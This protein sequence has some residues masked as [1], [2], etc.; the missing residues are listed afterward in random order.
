MRT[1]GRR[2]RRQTLWNGNIEPPLRT[3]FTDGD[4]IVR[5]AWKTHDQTAARIDDLANRHP[6]LTVAS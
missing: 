1:I 2:L 4:H 5:W 3:I 6:E